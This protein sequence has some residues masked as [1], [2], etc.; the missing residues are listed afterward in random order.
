MIFGV[1]FL[2][3]CNNIKSGMFEKYFI[4]LD[5]GT[6]ESFMYVSRFYLDS[7]F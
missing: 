6:F 7:I 3:P 4:C 2:Y 1:C 5:H